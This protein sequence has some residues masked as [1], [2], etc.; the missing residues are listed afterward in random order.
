MCQKYPNGFRTSLLHFWISCHFNDFSHWE[1]T[2]H[3]CHT[4]LCTPVFPWAFPSARCGQA[5][6]SY[7][8][9]KIR[10][11]TNVNCNL[12]LYIVFHFEPVLLSSITIM[13]TFVAVISVTMRPV[14][15]HTYWSH[16]W[17]HM[18]DLGISVTIAWSH[19]IMPSNRL[20]HKCDLPV[21]VTLMPS[22]AR[23]HKCD[24]DV[25][26]YTKSTLGKK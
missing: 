3:S 4:E 10:L 14:T 12:V 9:E 13:L 15:S 11:N 16:L 19:L 7:V 20:R 8:Y 2:R 23:R 24:L 1:I 22:I 18:C 21:K 6:M 5:A 17:R 26:L 25:L